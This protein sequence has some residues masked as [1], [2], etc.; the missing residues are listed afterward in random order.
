MQNY[1]N[2]LDFENLS[3]NQKTANNK[4][5]VISSVIDGFSKGNMDEELY[6]PYKNYKPV[7]LDGN[8]YNVMMKAYLFA[9]IDLQLYLD[10]HP[11]DLETKKLF[12][13]YVEEFNKLEKHVES[14]KGP[15]CVTSIYNTTP[16][17]IWQKDW[18]FEG[19]EK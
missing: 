4:D 14:K 17:W 19:D 15:L 6:D 11:D 3:R 7:R 10:V 13:K 16:N 12:N 1:V 9:I 8:D 5:I 2:Y 18:P